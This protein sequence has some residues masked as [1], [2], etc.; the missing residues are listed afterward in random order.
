VRG[1][2]GFKALRTNFGGGF[3]M[4][5]FVS[6]KLIRWW[7][8]PLLPALYAVNLMLLSN[9][10]CLAFFVLQNVFYALAIVGAILRRGGIQSKLFLVP[11]YF[12]MVN[13]A[14]CAAIVTYVSGRRLVSWEKAETTRDAHEHEGFAPQLRV[15]EGK[16]DLSYAG[17][18]KGMEN[19]ERIT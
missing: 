14:S 8:G 13:A 1:L 19:F 12:V 5:Q 4:F 7:V 15:I 10:L 9:P 18:R 2:T 16:K 6:R 11:F 17:K 3:R